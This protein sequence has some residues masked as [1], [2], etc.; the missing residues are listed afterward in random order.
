MARQETP[1]AV[2]QSFRSEMSRL[3]AYLDEARTSAEPWSL[4]AW[5]GAGG[6]A[7]KASLRKEAREANLRRGKK[8]DACHEEKGPA[9]T[10]RPYL[11]PVL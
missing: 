11:L 10:N 5:G 1:K 4:G 8:T 3:T 2:Y 6:E 7:R 9:W